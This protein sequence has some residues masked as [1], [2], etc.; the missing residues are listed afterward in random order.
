MAK[1]KCGYCGKKAGKR[2]CPSLDKIICPFCCGNNRLKNIVCEEDCKYLDHEIYQQKIKEEKELKSILES[3]PHS[4]NNDVL[5]N[6]K[7]AHIAYAFLT[8]ILREHITYRI[9]KSKKHLKIYI[10]INSK[11]KTSD[12]M[13]LLSGQSKYMSY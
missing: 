1:P 3:V 6:E 4:E 11:K 2:Y 12:R 10:F 7:G 5:K 9:R 8:V 13:N